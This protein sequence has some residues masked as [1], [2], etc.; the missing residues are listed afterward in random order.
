MLLAEKTAPGCTSLQLQQPLATVRDQR[1]R[2]EPLHAY[3]GQERATLP[4]QTCSA[5]L[6]HF[7]S[8]LA[9]CKKLGVLLTSSV[10]AM[11]P[12]RQ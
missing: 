2:G 10:H 6:K 4:A 8:S 3:L 1:G 12:P 7:I 5:L 9:Q 11:I